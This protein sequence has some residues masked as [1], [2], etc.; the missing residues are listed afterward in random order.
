MINE[1]QVRKQISELWV[2][3]NRYEI[4]HLDLAHMI[5]AYCEEFVD[6]EIEVDSETLEK[7]TDLQCDIDDYIWKLL[8]LALENERK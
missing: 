5:S 2:I 8:T 6:E 1:K 7:Y 3:L 4:T